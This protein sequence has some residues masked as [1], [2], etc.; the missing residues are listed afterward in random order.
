MGWREVQEEGDIYTHL[1]LINVDIWQKATHYCK[2]SI[3]QLKIV[4]KR[5]KNK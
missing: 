5:S 1:W 2:A 4:L 3:L